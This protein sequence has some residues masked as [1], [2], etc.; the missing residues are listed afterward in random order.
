[1]APGEGAIGTNVLGVV[2]TGNEST[3]FAAGSTVSFGD[4]ITVSNLANVC[5]GSLTVDLQIAGNAVPGGRLVT[6]TSPLDGG[7]TEVASLTNGFIISSSASRT[8]ASVTPSQGAQGQILDVAIVGIGTHFQQGVTF[9]NFGDGVAATLTVADQTH[10]TAHVTV[11]PTTTLGWRAV[12][13]ATGGEIASLAPV[14]GAGPGFNV[15]AGN[16]SLTTVDPASGVQGAASFVVTVTGSLT[17]FQQGAT[18]IS[19]GAGINVGQK[20]VISETEL[21]VSISLTAGATVGARDVIAT[22]GGE[23]ATLSNG[24]TVVSST[25]PQLDSV[26]PAEGAQGQTLTLTFEGSN[27]QFTSGTPTLTIGSSI[28][29]KALTVVDA[30]TI[31]ADINID[32]LALTGSR[33]GSLTAGGTTFPFNFTVL[34]SGA[35]IVGVTPPSG[36]QGGTVNV[37]VT[38]DA[39]H[40]QQGTTT[41]SFPNQCVEPIVN[42]ITITSAT[43]AVLNLQI[44]AGACVGPHLLQLATGGE[45]VTTSFGVYQATP[46]VGLSPSNAMVG[47]SLTVNFVGQFTHFNNGT[48]AVI[49]GTDVDIESFDVS[50]PASATARFAIAADAAPGLRTVTLTTPQGQGAFEIVTAAFAVGSTVASLTAIEPFHATPGSTTSVTIR[51][52]FTTFDQTTSVGFG[53]NVTTGPVNVLSQ[54]ELSVQVTVDAA[55]AIGWR[56]AF[57]NTG[58][59]QLT[60]GYRIDGPEAPAIVAVTP[61]SGV[62]GESLPVTIVGVNTTFDASSQLILGAGVTVSNFVVTS[63]TTA[64]ATVQISPTAPVGPNSVLVLTGEEIA[65]GAGFSVTRGAAQILSV[66]PSVAQQSQVL[67]VALVG[68]GTNWLQGATT[69][70]FGSG[71]I[72]N[73]LTVTDFTHATAQITVLSTAAAGF[74]TVATFTDG[75]YTSRVSRDSSSNWEH[76]SSRAARLILRRK[77]HPSSPKCSACTPSGCRM[78]RRRAT[79]K[80]SLSRVFRSTVRRAPSSLRPSIQPRSPVRCHSAAH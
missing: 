66:T 48:T 22:T 27:T 56:S 40:W 5:A 75:E 2:V 16:A 37:L 78:S 11:S 38:G 14:G 47:T 7:G 76:R 8:L 58:T 1:M 62:Q 72:V 57:V 43:S 10:A 4:G 50:S 61:S 51:G 64:T 49:D 21:T 33:Q 53:P 18:D 59:E 65:S 68:Q 36:P 67:N 19:F 41:A 74:H 73:Q 29:I 39:T 20:T 17:N 71:V 24:F 12:T 54:T 45:V 55:A 15:I 79:A 60:I 42:L 63:P 46:S 32:A 26:T 34:A 35:A 69:A 13:L 52:S 77:E 25:P 9:A 31:T 80:A 70:D 3:H 28:A 30:N 44:P 6:V 23:V